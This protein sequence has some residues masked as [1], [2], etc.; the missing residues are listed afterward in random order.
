MTKI[1]K[2]SLI[3]SGNLATN[4]GI[5]LFDSDIQIS[6]VYS[7]NIENSRQLA[8]QIGS[9]PIN[10]I[11]NLP[12]E[13]DLYILAV[14]DEAI[15]PIAG[16]INRY[17]GSRLPLV[18]TSGT[19]SLS[20]VEDY[21][22]LS[23]VLYFLQSFTR[24][25][26]IEFNGIP[27]FITTNNGEIKENL[28]EIAKNLTGNVK[29]I[30]DEKRK[31]LHLAAVFCNNFVNN[32]Y[33]V[34]KKIMADEDLPFEDLYPLINET[35]TRITQGEE[36]ENCQTGPAKRNE[37][38]II[39]EHLKYLEAYPKVRTIYEAITKNINPEVGRFTQ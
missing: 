25:R 32:L 9:I 7:R 38:I 27:C 11:K 39:R 31:I 21:F 12:Q 26:R 13:S 4:L 2:V 5:K 29:I 20:A 23:G 37:T 3:G 22:P 33:S 35:A 19:V 24:S 6:A 10:H 15:K 16:E 34:S 14:S 36:P 18:H 28:V 8:S 17:H 1:R 30:N